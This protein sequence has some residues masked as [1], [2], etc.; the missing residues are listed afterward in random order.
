MTERLPAHAL[1]NSMGSAAAA[2]PSTNWAA[3]GMSV[4]RVKEV[5]Y[6][7]LKCTL[8]V[9]TGE[10]DVYDYTGVDLTLPSGGR[11]HCMTS[12][13]ERGD[14][15]YVAWMAR[16][17]AGT[18][19]AKGPVI[20][21]WLPAAPWMGHEW[22][23]FQTMEPGEGM[24]TPRDR[25]VAAGTFDRVRFKLRHM[26]PGN[27]LASSSQGSD[28]HLDASVLLSNRRGNEIRLRDADQALVV[29]SLQ[30][31]HAAAGVR[32]YAGMVQRDARLLPST[33]FSD[34]KYWDAPRQLDP[35]A[36]P[37]PVHDMGTAPFPLNYLTPGLV[38]RR[39]ADMNRSGFEVATGF[40][41]PARLDPFDFLQW[42]AFITA[43]G[44]RAQSDLP[45]G[46]ANTV[47]GG[48]A[49]YR[50]GLDPSG[51]VDNAI[52][53]AL[54]AEELPPP[55][56]TEHRIEVTHTA[57][58]TLPVTEQTDGFDADRLPTRNPSAGDP[59]AQSSRV[60]FV[61][62]V[63]GSV[64]GNDPYSY[65]GR[66]LYGLPLQPQVFTA[67]GELAP[68][69]I[70]AVGAPLRDHAATLL[71]VTPLI[72]GAT[73][74]SFAS[75]TKD[76]RFKAYVAGGPI[77]AE[78]ATSG[79]LALSVGGA[80]EL[81]LQ[82]GLHLH[83]TPG[84][85]N[86]GL[87]LSSPTGAVVVRGGGQLNA[88]SAA[89][90]AAPGST[91][92]NNTPSLLL[93]GT[94]NAT[95]RSEGSVLV[96][97]PEIGLT[98]AG[99]IAASAQNLLTLRSGGRVSLVTQTH[100]VIVS[101]SETVNYGGPRDSNPANGPSRAVT[102]SATPATGS[103]GGT[104]DRYTMVFGDRVEEFQTVGNHTTRSLAAGN[105][106]YETNGGRW[107]ARAGANRM[108]LSAASGLATTVGTGSAS[109]VVATG[110]YDLT[111]QTGVNLRSITGSVA[112][113]GATGVA[114]VSPVGATVSGPIMCGS[115]LDPMTGL[116]FSTYMV[117]R[118]QVLRPI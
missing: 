5:L 47:Y 44:Y 95:L 3:L 46:D 48:K 100:D 87:N 38:F 50:V 53:S 70:S 116:P 18:A 51:A 63:L 73:G 103:I 60:P 39:Y 97:A 64:V 20:V 6:E 54:N 10:R 49:M 32:S 105:L 4:A 17:S 7:D 115:D 34:G 98:N 22:I 37:R 75:W 15:C 65:A 101:G 108:E 52:A 25:A 62:W 102:F 113:T 90:D 67:G 28:L 35:G 1:R 42:G 104:T 19:S 78:V 74:A 12:L 40:N 72:P 69:M 57:D 9:L 30:Q 11:R 82:G 61:E 33:M 83:G 76:G 59:L 92:G 85:G 112:V 56:L 117:P 23:P 88:G 118:G 26:A 109:T 106:T 14:L 24:D 84:A 36:I 107:V 55:A 2:D 21:G 77:S 81:F 91:S 41:I 89:R 27:V 110:G 114:L 66:P 68:G 80:L 8:Q 94:Q 58:G 96:Q 79:D 111:A 86:V 93:E 45:G 29:R 16:E 71:R 13:P 31:F 43:E 99:T